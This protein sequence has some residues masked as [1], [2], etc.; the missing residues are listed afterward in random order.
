MILAVFIDGVGL[1]SADPVRNPLADPSYPDIGRLL[2]E[3]VPLDA[4]L[5][6]DGLPQSASGQTALFCGVNAPQLCG[7]HRPGF[8]GPA[9]RRLL[10]AGTFY[11]R[12]V[13]AG[14]RATFLNAFGLAYLRR[15]AGGEARASASTLAATSAS[16]P[17]RTADDV[18][19][20]EAIYHDLSGEGLA[21]QG[22]PVPTLT[23]VQAAEIAWQVAQD[24]DLTVFEFFLTD[25]A[26]HRRDPSF[27]RMVL[28]RLDAFL[29]ELMAAASR[30]RRCGS[31]YDGL[32]VFSDHGNIEDASTALHTRN[33][34]PLVIWPPERG[35][36]LGAQPQGID[37]VAA[38]LADLALEGRT[39]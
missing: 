4:C 33:P 39:G 34:V 18:A 12:V 3:A 10:A 1:G 9:L 8:P 17:L 20:G 24:Y 19:R 15:M 26:G 37:D 13:E 35:G 32:V 25:R 16:L 38:I 7:G 22:Q 23:A 36:A 27:T 5:G 2:Q 11:D 30:P 6:V 14:G 31:C 21:Q 28:S 29:G